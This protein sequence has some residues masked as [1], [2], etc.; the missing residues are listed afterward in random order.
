M[1]VHKTASSLLFPSN[2][3]LSETTKKAF[4]IYCN[5]GDFAIPLKICGIHYVTP[6]YRF[7]F[8]P[9]TYP[10]SEYDN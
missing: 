8:N 3:F 9:R 10:S 7:V 5:F 6:Y 4:Q 2:S 1:R